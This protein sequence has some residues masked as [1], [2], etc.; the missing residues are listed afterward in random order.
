MSNFGA[1]GIYDF[2]KVGMVILS[3]KKKKEVKLQKK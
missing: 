2:Y 3:Q 1:I